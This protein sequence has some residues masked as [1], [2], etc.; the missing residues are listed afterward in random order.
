MDTASLQQSR[1][2]V[3]KMCVIKDL[4]THVHDSSLNASLFN[5][6]HSTPGGSA[7]GCNSRDPLS[8]PPVVYR[9]V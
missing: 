8:F 2:E 4:L 9:L 6:P 1:A 7:S 3:I 5:R